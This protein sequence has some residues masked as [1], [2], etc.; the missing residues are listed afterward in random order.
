MFFLFLFRRRFNRRLFSIPSLFFYFYS[1]SGLSLSISLGFRYRLLVLL[2]MCLVYFISYAFVFNSF[3]LRFKFFVS[4]LLSPLI[5]LFILAVPLIYRSTARYGASLS[6]FIDVL[7]SLYSNLEVLLTTILLETNT[8]FSSGAVLTS[9]NP[10]SI[11]PILN[12]FSVF[13][14][15]S[16]SL[17]S[18]QYLYDNISNALAL[19]HSSGQAYHIYVEWYFIAGHIGIVIAALAYAFAFSY[20]FRLLLKRKTTYKISSLYFFLYTILLA[21]IQPTYSRGYLVQPVFTLFS[22]IVWP[23]F[24]LLAP[25]FSSQKPD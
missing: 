16:S 15:F 8:S 6:Q 9:V 19:S 22:F 23:L 25:I 7:L 18:S 12:L 10:F 20:T 11:E 2:V 21:L 13:N 4:L 14:P 17:T 24:I 3:S 5:L 1:F